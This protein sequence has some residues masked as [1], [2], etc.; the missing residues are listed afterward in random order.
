MI[1]GSRNNK[2]GINGRDEEVEIVDLGK[3]EENDRVS[4]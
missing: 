1:K 3:K 2:R 4:L